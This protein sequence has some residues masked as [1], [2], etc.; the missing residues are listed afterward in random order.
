MRIS[1][2]RSLLALAACL[3][4]S[5]TLIAPAHAQDDD[6][7]AAFD[8][9]VE[10]RVMNVDVEVVDGSGRPVT[11]LRQQDFRLTVDGQPVEISNFSGYGAA[12]A[13]SPQATVEG[14]AGTTAESEEP[15]IQLA[16]LVDNLNLRPQN[17][18]RLLS[19]MDALLATALASEDRLLV[20]SLD[21]RLTVH[22]PFSADRDA[23]RTALAAVA[24]KPARGGEAD[25]ERRAGIDAATAVMAEEGPGSASCASLIE[26][27]ID[28]YARWT[29]ARSQAAVQGM[30]QLLQILAGVPGR[31]LLV[32][33]SDGVQLR[34]GSDLAFAFSD[35][36]DSFDGSMR[37]AGYD[38]SRDFQRLAADANSARVTF[39]PLESLGDQNGPGELRASLQDSLRLLADETGGRALLNAASLEG[40]LL[41]ALAA[42]ESY[43]SLGF[44]PRSLSGERAKDEHRIEVALNRPGL[45]IRYRQSFRDKSDAELRGER[46]LAALWLG[47]ADN[48]LGARIEQPEPPRATSEGFA[49]TLRLGVPIANMGLVP[50]EDRYEGRFE[51][52]VAAQ[53]ASGDRTTLQED[54]FSVRIPSRAIEAARGQLYGYQLT[55]ELPAGE[56]RLAIAIRDRVTS[57]TSYLRHTLQLSAATAAGG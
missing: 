13:P 36:C 2:R 21:D 44:D 16:I 57:Q 24:A 22:L 15:P 26:A 49:V 47:E 39:L 56:Y 46:L 6:L 5:L 28:P 10:V 27:A 30:G 29:I 33:I 8:D 45:R 51:I 43:Y 48:P 50:R 3:Y 40:A 52:Y 38:R 32:Y 19:Q 17:R 25:A 9:T 54:G 23:L 14:A 53:P 37:A 1:I 4:A 55:L 7:L 34:P 12:P 42:A 31:K 11:G 20:A 35:L 41:P 18:Q